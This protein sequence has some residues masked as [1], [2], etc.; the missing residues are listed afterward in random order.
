[1][2]IRKLEEYCLNS[3]HPRGRHKARVLASVGIRESDAEEL[4]RALLAAAW[5]VTS[6]RVLQAL[7]VSAISWISI[8]L[9]RTGRVK[10]RTRYRMNLSRGQ[11]VRCHLRAQPR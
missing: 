8:Y 4:R 1:M 6:N 5:L 11:V 2:D 7:T 10:N 3:Q 9:E